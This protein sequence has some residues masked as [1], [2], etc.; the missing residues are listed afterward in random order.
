M[1]LIAK[2]MARELWW[3]MLW[4]MRRRWMKNLQRASLRLV[5]TERRAHAWDSMRRQNALARRFGLPI[6]VLAMNLVLASV[7]IT[8]AYMLLLSLSES[9]ALQV[10]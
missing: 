7:V 5:R 6:L 4:L 2:L 9:G 3:A 10:P 8:G 1:S